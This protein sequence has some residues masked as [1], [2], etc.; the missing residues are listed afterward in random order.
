M[1]YGICAIIKNENLFLREWIEHHISI[2]FDTICLYEDYDSLSHKDITMHYNNVHLNH[3]S[4][5]G[6]ENLIETD[7]HF[8]G[9]FRQYALYKWF[10]TNNPYDLDWCAFIDID[11]YIR[12]DDNY[13]LKKI[14]NEFNNKEGLYL[15]WRMYGANKH[16]DRPIGNLCDNYTS[17]SSMSDN[18]GE[19]IYKSFINLRNISGEWINMHCIPGLCNTLGFHS[20]RVRTHKKMWIDHYITK[21]WQDWCERFIKRGEENWG[22]RKLDD[23]FKHNK[24]MLDIKSEL[25]EY[26][27]HLKNKTNV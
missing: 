3:I 10:K 8:K 9:C 16:I 22:C 11:E 17:L 24:D 18:D 19:I 2:G 20:S 14:C 27:E 15:K 25:Y 13:S 7:T 6:E 5:I 23:F 12:F 1:K 26:Y 21:S 4:S